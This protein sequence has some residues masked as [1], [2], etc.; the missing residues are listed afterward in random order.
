MAAPKFQFWLSSAS[1]QT[2]FVD[3]AAILAKISPGTFV[4]ASLAQLLIGMPPAITLVHFC[5]GHVGVEQ[6]SEPAAFLMATLISQL[7]AT[8]EYD[9]RE[10]SQVESTKGHYEALEWRDINY[11]CSFFKYLV[12]SLPYG[13]MF[14]LIDD[15]FHLEHYTNPDSLSAVI[16]TFAELVEATM[17]NRVVNFKVLV[18]TPDRKGNVV[19]FATEQDLLSLGHDVRTPSQP[20]MM[21]SKQQRYQYEY[22]RRKG[23]GMY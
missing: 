15:F 8:R 20:N 2:L 19:R 4:T 16:R 3:P 10:W 18:M 13:T 6:D 21:M 14:C 1:S 23:G 7:L 22:A 11:L 17:I 5:R 12:K 9:L